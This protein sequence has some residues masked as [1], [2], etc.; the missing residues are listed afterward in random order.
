VTTAASPVRYEIRAMS[1]AEI[2]DMGFRLLRD[3]FV[4]I[5]GLGATLQ[6]P[7]ALLQAWSG[8]KLGL[9]A[10]MGAPLIGGAITLVAILVVAPIVSAAVTYAIGD[11]YVG[12]P[13]TLGQALRRALAIV[14]PLTATMLLIVLVVVLV[15]VA[16]VTP[17]LV[18]LIAP[19]V[20]PAPPR[21]LL[22]G[23]LVLSFFAWI[24][25]WLGFLVVTQV[26][27]L[28]GTFGRAALRRSR[29]LMRGNRLRGFGIATI[30][31]LIVGVLGGVLQLAL[32]YVPI[33]GPA[34]AGVAQA[35]GTAYTSAV[36][37][38]FYFDI[39]CRK[40]A[41]DLEHLAMLV[42]R[43]SEASP[44]LAGSTG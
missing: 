31:A 9:Q 22:A 8:G 36:L 19:S 13:P 34:A 20:L 29:V 38:V 43:A 1:F 2:L 33:V 4:L 6:V 16:L 25:L 37:V 32:G 41:F 15:T 12:Q 35:A 26:M 28:E 40:E 14:L 23:G 27:I 7:L 30:G 21:L 11:A 18:A 44:A 3:H 17:G 10:P 24:H 39:R 5:V 42:T